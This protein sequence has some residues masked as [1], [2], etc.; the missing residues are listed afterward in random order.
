MLKYVTENR[1]SSGFDIREKFEAGLVLSGSEVKASKT[2]QLSLR[3]SFVKFISGSL[4]VLGMHIGRYQKS[5]KTINVSED[6]SR[7]LLLRKSELSRLSGL[8]SQKGMVAVPLKVYIKNNFL[9][10]EFGVGMPLRKWQ[11]KEKL[12]ERQDLRDTE[13][14]LKQ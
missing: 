10:L 5:G 8:L 2:G 4:F 14:L 13:R 1:E 9:K 11:K 3:G 7:K 12:I 6:R